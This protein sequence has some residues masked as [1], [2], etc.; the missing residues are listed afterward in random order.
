MSKSPVTVAVSFLLDQPL[1]E[2]TIP[3]LWYRYAANPTGIEITPVTPLTQDAVNPLNWQ[4]QFT[5]A[6]E[7]GASGQDYIEFFF[8]AQDDLGNVGQ[9]ISASVTR[10]FEVYQGELPSLSIPANVAARALP[11]GKVEISWNAVAGSSGY[12]LWRMAPSEGNLSLYGSMVSGVT[13]T[14]QTV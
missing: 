8:Q 1:K 7:V 14:D 2:E 11:G 9:T 10:Q 12:W 3:Q 4:A 13:F 5:L 6:P